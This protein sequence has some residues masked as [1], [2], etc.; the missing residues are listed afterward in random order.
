MQ[1]HW[2]Q[3]LE[4]PRGPFTV[5]VDKTWE[6]I[7]PGDLF[8]DTVT[9]I[10]EVCRKI[11]R[12][13]LDWFILRARVFYEGVEL[14][15]EIV[16]GFLYEDC[17]EVLTDGVAEDLIDEAIDGAIKEALRLKGSFDKLVV[18]TV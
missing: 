17:R 16:G 11:D 3:L 13:L 2:D 5:I 18:P 10:A 14:S 7:H 15:S 8:D 1:H 9:D 4:T 6:D 12:G